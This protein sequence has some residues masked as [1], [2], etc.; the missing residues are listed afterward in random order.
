[1][2][3][4]AVVPVVAVNHCLEKMRIKGTSICKRKQSLSIAYP[5]L[6]KGESMRYFSL[7]PS[8]AAS[9]GT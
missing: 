2:Q 3:N 8:L 9:A 6:A 5:Y 4:S 1:M 7:R